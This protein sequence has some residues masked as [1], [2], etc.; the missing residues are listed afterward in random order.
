M[1]LYNSNVNLLSILQSNLYCLK[2]AKIGFVYVLLR[3]Q[4]TEIY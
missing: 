3:A 2:L 4:S 1:K